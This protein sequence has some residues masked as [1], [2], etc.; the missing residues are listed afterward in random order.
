MNKEYDI[1]IPIDFTPVAKSSVN[2]VLGMSQKI[3]LTITLL[4]VVEKDN[5]IQLAEKK[6]HDF[7]NNFD[8]GAIKVITKVI[9]G[10]F[11]LDIGKVS[12]TLESSLIVMGT[13]G[14]KGM[15]KLFGS[16]A[17]KV[18]SNS[19]I[20]LLILQEKTIYSD[21]KTIAMTIDLEKESIQIVK[22]AAVFAKSFNAKILLVGGKHDDS[23]LKKKVNTN[24][25]LCTDFLTNNNIEHE[26]HFLERKQFDLNFIEFCKENKVDMLSATYYMQTFYAF[27]DKF[28]QN[29]ITNEM[30]I[31]LI[32]VDSTSTTIN[33][34]YSFI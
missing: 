27:S 20:P 31:P 34:Q 14:E 1:L 24:I 15:Q 5:E 12:K 13:H 2:Y 22:S 3:K 28:V 25:L 33:S 11:L 16:N 7:K 6:F 9:K 21:I 17:L 4:H 18:V 8:F 29:L 19:K 30:S 32:T 23:S 10:N 26:F